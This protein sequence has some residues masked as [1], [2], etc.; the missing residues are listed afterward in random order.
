MK[1]VDVMKKIN[2]ASA[3]MPIFMQEGVYGEKREA[4]GAEFNGY[5]YPERDRTVTSISLCNG[6][7]V[8]H[9]K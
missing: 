4:H 8:V 5:N 6:Y 7:V 1:V 2:G 3:K 9:Y